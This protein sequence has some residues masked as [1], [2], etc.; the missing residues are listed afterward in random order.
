LRTIHETDLRTV[1]ETDLRTA[2][3]TDLRTVKETDLRTVFSLPVLD[4]QMTWLVFA[5]E[6]RRKVFVMMALASLHPKKDKSSYAKCLSNNTNLSFSDFFN[7]MVKQFIFR[8]KAALL[9]F[10]SR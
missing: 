7:F 1:N 8:E 2:N 3:E 9:F 10:V 5:N 4:T 6:Y